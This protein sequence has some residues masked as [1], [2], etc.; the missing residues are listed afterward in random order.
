MRSDDAEEPL[1][2]VVVPDAR[3]THQQ[4]HCGGID[5]VVLTSLW[6]WS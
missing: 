3:P 4:H 6:W 1:W 5:G 2:N